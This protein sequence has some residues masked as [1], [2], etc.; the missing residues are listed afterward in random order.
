MSVKLAIYRAVHSFVGGAEA[1]APL[2]KLS[3]NTLRHMA[4]PKKQTHGWSLRR[5]DELLALTGTEPLEALC[6]DHGG[7]FVPMPAVT[8]NAPAPL[9][10]A[11]HKLAR[12]YGDVP[13]AVEKALKRDGQISDNELKQIDQELAELVA[14]GAQLLGMVRQIHDSRAAIAEEQRP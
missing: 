1:L 9:L 7:I 5:F 4:D 2:M 14:A 10:K 3:P 11:L 8:D 13:R 6:Q 12:E